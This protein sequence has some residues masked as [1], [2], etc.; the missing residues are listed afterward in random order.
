MF[1]DHTEHILYFNSTLRFFLS[2][3][4][5]FL[6]LYTY[7]QMAETFDSQSVALRAQKKL[8]G[9]MATKKIAK[10]FIDDT[11]GRLLDNVYRITKVLYGNK[12]SLCRPTNHQTVDHDYMPSPYQFV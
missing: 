1:A 10:V 9:K 3:V 12:Y 6:I 2:G 5:L 4:F 8:L 7:L 11:S